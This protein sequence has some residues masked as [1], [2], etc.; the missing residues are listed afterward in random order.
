MM[1]INDQPIL[2]GG[3]GSSGTTLV[4][5]LLNASSSIFCGPEL[6]LFNKKDLYR[7]P[8]RYTAGDFN[9]LLNKG[10]ATASTLNT[11]FL[12]RSTFFHPYSD[13][14]FL[15]NLSAYGYNPREVCEMAASCPDFKHFVDSFYKRPL[16]F[17]QKTVWAEKSPTNI[18]CIQE[19]LSLYPSGRYIH[20]VRDGR[21]VIPSLMLRG[22]TPEAAVRR[23]LHDTAA[24]YPHRKSDRYLEIRYEDLVFQPEE[25]LDML[26]DFLNIN[27]KAA[28]VLRRAKNNEKAYR[29]HETWTMQPDQEISP[30]ATMKWKRQEFRKKF[31]IEQLFCYT[32]LAEKLAR[33]WELPLPCS[34]NDILSLF[35]YDHKDQW[36]L[37]PGRGLRFM[38]HYLQERLFSKLRPLELCCA[39]SF[40]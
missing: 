24:G 6:Y 32:H 20:V 22:H 27:E 10:L 21:D 2:I 35:G 39:V 11:V 16:E 28:N 3:S 18:Y 5:N 19:F 38:W 29:V 37:Q 26:F 25:T 30:R 33:S 14:S 36:N 7:R 23:W 31:F 13:F 12:S 40:N 1:K 34:G 8:F 9:V 17:A 4:A 15:L